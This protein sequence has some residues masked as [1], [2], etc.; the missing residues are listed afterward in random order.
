MGCRTKN[1]SFTFGVDLDHNQDPG[2]FTTM[3]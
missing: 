3:E 1:K 2:I